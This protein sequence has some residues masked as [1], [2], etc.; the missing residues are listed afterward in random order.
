MIV[1]QYGKAL[2]DMGANLAVGFNL[3][4]PIATTE[5]NGARLTE[6]GML[7]ISAEVSGSGFAETLEANTWLQRAAE[8]HNLSRNINDYILVAVP[9]MVTRMP[10]T[11]GDSVDLKQFTAWNEPCARM[12][13]K[14]WEGRP[15]YIEHQHKPEWVRGL[16]FGTFMRPTKFKNIHKLVMLAAL[17]RTRD[18]V[19]CAR[20]LKRELNTYSMGMMYSAYACSVCGHIAGKGIGAP[21]S[22][23]RPGK[24]TY[25]LTDGRL[26]YRRCM[27]ITGFELSLL[28]NVGGRHGQDGYTQGFGDPSY[29]SAIGDIILDPKAV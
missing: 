4:T 21:C 12:A 23:T 24:P 8:Y 25:R 15:M 3:G 26:V 1:D 2:S 19:R 13:F 7:P 18:Q 10:N 16:I 5:L 20:V 28:E 9:A 11:N 29:V 14:T 17:D 22:H 6:D 27:N